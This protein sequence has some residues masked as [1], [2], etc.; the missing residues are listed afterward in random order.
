MCRNP[1][2]THLLFYLLGPEKYNVLLHTLVLLGST[3]LQNLHHRTIY[4]AIS[5]FPKG[6]GNVEEDLVCP[7]VKLQSLG[8]IGIYLYL[9]VH[10]TLHTQAAR[11][12]RFDLVNLTVE[13]AVSFRMAGCRCGYRI[14]PPNKPL[15]LG[16]NIFKQWGMNTNVYRTIIRRERLNFIESHAREPL[17]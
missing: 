15:I 9:I 11:I 17:I 10:E 6:H 2:P 4:F 12:P 16:L 8:L 5:F 14:S 1:R 13:S 7:K 3:I